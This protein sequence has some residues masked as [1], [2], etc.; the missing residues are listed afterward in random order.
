MSR[1]V[2]TSRAS[3]SAR[4]SA[5]WALRGAGRRL[6]RVRPH[7]VTSHL[8][9]ATAA[10]GNLYVA[11]RVFLNELCVRLT[12]MAESLAR[13]IGQPMETIEK[14]RLVGT[15]GLYVLHRRLLPN[16]IVRAS[17]ATVC[18][19]LAIAPYLSRCVGCTTA[20]TQQGPVQA[21]VAHA[22]DHPAHPAVRPCGVDRCRLPQRPHARPHQE[23]EAKGA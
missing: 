23:L 8:F 9:A 3:T 4:T 16:S 6:P 12:K 10:A 19:G 15:F 1:R 20:E 13:V 14:R 2:T 7:N 5:C 22:R 17:P 11:R 18:A 21:V